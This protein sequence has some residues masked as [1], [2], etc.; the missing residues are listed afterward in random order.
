ME[1]D[2]TTQGVKKM[3]HSYSIKCS[4]C[5]YG[6]SVIEG[7]G[8]MYSPNAVFYGRCDDPKQNWSVSFPDGYCERD[9]PLL[10]TLVKCDKIKGEDFKPLTPDTTQIHFEDIAHALSLTCRANALMKKKV[11]DDCPSIIGEP[12]FE[13]RGFGDVEKEFINIYKKGMTDYD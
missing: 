12:D 10:L 2:D 5:D 8:M 13:F 11:F 4:D 7:V 3:G 9:K 6:L 1:A